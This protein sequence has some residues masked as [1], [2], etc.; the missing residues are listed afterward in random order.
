MT[1]L[2]NIL[3]AGPATPRTDAFA[4]LLCENNSNAMVCSDVELLMEEASTELPDMVIVDMDAEDGSDGFV[5]GERLRSNRETMSIPIVAWKGNPYP[6]IYQRALAVG[7]DDVYSGELRQDE[8]CLRLHPIM[9]LSTQLAELRRRT[10]LARDFGVDIPLKPNLTVES[11]PFSVLAVAC[12]PE[13]AAAIESAMGDNA[14]LGHCESPIYARDILNDGRFDSAVIGLNDPADV[15]DVLEFCEEVRNNPRLFNLPI[16]ILRADDIDLDAA[17][18]MQHG[19]SRL[20]R[21]AKAAMSLHFVLATWGNRQRLRWKI[22]D[23]VQLTRSDSTIDKKTGAYPVR[24]LPRLPR[25]AD[26]RS[27]GMAAP[28]DASRLQFRR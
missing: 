15:E 20:L 21:P 12:K 13:Q 25:R 2:A 23:A 11:G 22:R 24:F 6:E 1:R 10:A 28:R 26:G 5:I 7:F 27:T 8:L 17:T 4:D 9:R 16:V 3:I 19:A 14:I 18:A